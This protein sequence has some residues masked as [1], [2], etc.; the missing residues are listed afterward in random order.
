MGRSTSVLAPEFLKK[1][2]V[3]PG[4]LA[5]AGATRIGNGKRYNEKGIFP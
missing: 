4:K 5:I 2:L 3:I 1:P